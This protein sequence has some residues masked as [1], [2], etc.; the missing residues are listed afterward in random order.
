[1]PSYGT[2]DWW[3][4]RYFQSDAFLSKVSDRSKPDYRK[5]LK[6]IADMAPT[7]PPPGITRIGQL[8]AK[9]ITPAAVDKLYL[10]LRGGQEG[11]K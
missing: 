6:K 11:K 10:L 9:S 8:P 4:E 5:A 7:K 2:V 3:F 1:M